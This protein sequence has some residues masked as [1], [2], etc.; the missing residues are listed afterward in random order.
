MLIRLTAFYDFLEV[1]GFAQ[2]RKLMRAAK[3]GIPAPSRFYAE[4]TF[5]LRMNLHKDGGHFSRNLL[6]LAKSYDRIRMIMVNAGF[7][8]ESDLQASLGESVP[9]FHIFEIDLAES[10]IEPNRLR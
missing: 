8:L 6:P 4:D 1:Y 9:Q 10:F 5:K 7:R 2:S 3:F